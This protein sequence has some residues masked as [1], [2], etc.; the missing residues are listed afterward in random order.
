M[1]VTSAG[2]PGQGEARQALGWRPLHCW[3][4]CTVVQNLYADA[5]QALE[6]FLYIEKYIFPSFQLIERQESSEVIPAF[7]SPVS[8]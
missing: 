2:S 6:D 1:A 8:P 4:S 7:L 5:G 3:Q